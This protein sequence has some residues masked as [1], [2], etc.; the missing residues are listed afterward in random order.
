[1]GNN[2]AS[3]RMPIAV[4]AARTKTTGITIDGGGSAITTGQKGYIQC[5]FTG[6][7]TQCTLVAD[8]VGSCVVDIW[9]TTYAGA[10]PTVANTITAAA[11]PT[12]AAA[13]KSTDVTL[14]GWT[15]AVVTGDVLGF[16]VNSASTIT[17]LS[18]ILW[19]RPT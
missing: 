19:I 5:P 9:K 6:T 3:L 14:T 17:R 1:M 13:I 12:L 2:F 4:E 7:I 8:Q 16:N 18:L 11:L 15:T 10:P